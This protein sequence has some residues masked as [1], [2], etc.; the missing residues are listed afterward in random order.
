MSTMAVSPSAPEPE[1]LSTTGRIVNTLVAPSKTFLD[2]KR[3]TTW[4]SWFA[5]WLV[6]VAVSLG[7]A[8]VV[9]QKVGFEQVLQNNLQASPK[10]AEQVEKL[11]PE[12]RAQQMKISF[13]ITKAIT[14]GFSLLVLVGAVLVGGLLMATFNFGAGAEVSF[15]TSL[16]IVMYSSLMG[17][18]GDA[19]AMVSLL[20]G[21][22]PEGFFIQNPVATNPA[23]FMNP[24]D[25]PALYAFLAS[26][27]VISIW[28]WV[29]YAIGF[30]CVSK[31]NKGTTLT[32]AFAWFLLITLIQVGFAA[33]FN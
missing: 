19:L 22:D 2:L 1:P 7:Y 29:L 3:K 12:Q 6:I 24:A 4:T 26:L 25:S 9:A 20:V 8:A 13:G 14:Y 27:N 17:A 10:Q 11:P 33:A 18:V 16:A 31:M 23:Y 5:P 30:S 28:K 15:K 21:A 32:V